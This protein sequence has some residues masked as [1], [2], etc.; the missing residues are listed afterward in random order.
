MD[1]HFI[2]R[3]Y[4]WIALIAG[5]AAV[6]LSILF[7]GS[8]RM[9]LVGSAVAGTLGFCY[10]VQQQKLAEMLLFHQLFTTFNA[11]YNALN[12]KLALLSPITLLPPRI[13]HRIR[14][15]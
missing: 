13:V 1:R 6:F 5:G 4:W 2:F 12:G 7:G 11:R 3:N 15:P 10:F 8:E 9:G 14:L